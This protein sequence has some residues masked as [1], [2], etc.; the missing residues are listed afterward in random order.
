[1]QQG[2]KQG[3]QKKLILFFTITCFTSLF[4]LWLSSTMRLKAY[5][6]AKVIEQFQNSFTIQQEKI[7]EIISL[8]EHSIDSLMNLAIGDS[9]VLMFKFRNNTMEKWNSS[10]L[11]FDDI[12]N[13]KY[14]QNTLLTSNNTQ[15]FILN[16]NKKNEQDT[17]KYFFAVPLINFDN[18]AEKIL[19]NE[20]LARNIMAQQLAIKE[21]SDINKTSYPIFNIDKKP[22]FYVEILNDN[23]LI[24][25]P[26]QIWLI[27]IFALAYIL[28]VHTIGIMW[29]R[30]Q[31]M[32]GWL[33]E[34]LAL[35]VGY[36]LQ[37][38][39]ESYIAPINDKVLF[40]ST[41]L[42][43]SDY[44][45]NL[46]ELAYILTALTL[47]C[48]TTIRVIQTHATRVLAA[49]PYIIRWVIFTVIAA[50]ISY[51]IYKFNNSNLDIIVFDSK[52]SLVADNIQYINISSFIG[53]C[54][55]ICLAIIS[56][57]CIFI[58]WLIAE[59]CKFKTI[60]HTIVFIIINSTICF[61][62]LDSAHS[63]IYFQGFI[64]ITIIY[65]I[66]QFIPLPFSINNT[67][68]KNNIYW[69]I[70]VFII[71]I[72]S[73][74]CITYLNDIKEKE[75]RLHYALSNFKKENIKFEFNFSEQ[76][77][78][79]TT[80]SIIYGYATL[81]E[82]D[83]VAINIGNYITNRYF[84]KL[85]MEI[86]LHTSF[87]QDLPNDI[88]LDSLQY[89]EDFAQPYIYR[90]ATRIADKYIVIDV[91][92]KDVF[93]YKKNKVEG[94]L[95][96]KASFSD[97]QYLSK[98][99]TIKYQ[100]NKMVTYDGMDENLKDLPKNLYSKRNEQNYVLENKLTYGKMYLFNEDGS[101][102]V[103]IKYKRN[104]LIQ[105]IT[106]LSIAVFI[107]LIAFAIH[108]LLS[109]LFNSKTNKTEQKGIHINMNA[110]I[111]IAI[112][113]SIVT[114]IVTVGVIIVNIISANDKS[115]VTN[116]SIQ[117][118]AITKT[119]LE[120]SKEGLNQKISNLV[121]KFNIVALVYDT[122][123]VLKGDYHDI[124][125]NEYLNNKY[126]LEPELTDKIKSSN[127]QFESIKSK[128]NFNNYFNIY[129]QTSIN[130]EPIILKIS[131]YNNPNA[132]GEN[133]T[134]II[135]GVINI[136][137]LIIFLAS[138]V[139]YFVVKN[140]LKPIRIITNQ[141]QA[142]S[143]KHNEP[144][145]WPHKDEFS[146]LVTEYNNMIQKVETLANKLSAQ[147][148]E[149][150]WR[151]V[152]QQVAHEIKNPLTPM[153]LNIQYLQ[154]AI[155]DNRDNIEGLTANVCKVILEQIETLN[156][157]A[158][159]F[160]S[161]AKHSHME[162]E[163]FIVDEVIDNLVQLFLADEQIHISFNNGLG[164]TKVFM[165]K[166]F[167]IRSIT[168][169][170]KNAIQAIPTDK[171]AYIHITSTIDKNNIL[172][173]IEDNGTGIPEHI[174]DKLFTPYFTSKST[175]TGIGLFMTKNMIEVSGGTITYTSEK[176][177][178]TTFYIQLPI[179]AEE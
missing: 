73:I 88:S 120:N 87:V 19:L 161:L 78:A 97:Y 116:K 143:L 103:A 67:N 151:E 34:V 171:E 79:I 128:D 17:L 174:K 60:W 177:K 23:F 107:L 22:A 62:V 118:I 85:E 108:A 69:Q 89:I 152:A 114:S 2:R 63:L 56:L 36:V 102:C 99:I 32:M 72:Y 55:M 4:C 92:S 70:W 46:H 141:F 68:K 28:A 61:Y 137:I 35:A 132:S 130:N 144:I 71:S 58:I 122:T 53:N 100:D 52:I 86:F 15:Y 6:S 148:R 165:D 43:S 31:P 106:T 131:D 129:S 64:A 51:F 10:K 101:Q 111:N 136:L 38:E 169:I 157:I 159:D 21:V 93:Y 173:A 25:T 1:M 96:S 150:L 138:I 139:T 178:G 145:N 42:A 41:F 48:I 119:F 50:V 45:K 54:L 124:S 172:L 5:D 140:S 84:P 105:I 113:L 77:D 109:S 110:K 13:L 27:I 91:T 115:S 104:L 83:S 30:I 162:P 7:E 170:I 125:A 74:I 153:R 179:M 9:C 82:K 168:N 8:S 81:Q 135:L 39:I 29:I 164:N 44:Y 49:V 156:R 133:T 160:S 80:D 147:E 98:Y 33:L 16:Y 59:S 76:I 24:S 123:G 66:F 37:T 134:D 47:L 155:A 26:L 112:I 57:L 158:T 175:G 94:N 176:D 20:I 146:G 65:I 90:Y 18:N 75:F 154:R 40:S 126:L 3:T 117:T 12:K 167:L 121:D 149:S 11:S 166:S 95:I 163:T 142:I 127:A 14:E